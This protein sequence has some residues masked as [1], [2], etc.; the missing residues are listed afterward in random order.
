MN[1]RVA[2]VPLVLLLAVAVG[3]CEARP[4]AT[5]PATAAALTW[6]SAINLPFDAGQFEAA[7]RGGG[8][9]AGDATA[10]VELGDGWMPID[11]SDGSPHDGL[12]GARNGL[13]AWAEGGR[14][15]TSI[16]GLSWTD[17]VV[18]PGEANVAAIVPLGDNLV[19]LGEGVGRRIGAWTSSDGTAWSPLADAP[20]GMAAGTEVPGPG[21]VAVGRTGTDAAAWL[22]ADGARWRA[23]PPVR[24]ADGSAMAAVTQGAGSVVAVGTIGEIVVTWRSDDLETWSA[25]VLTAENDVSIRRIGYV[26]GMFVIAGQLNDKPTLWQS[27]DGRA[28]LA[29]QLPIPAA[30]SGTAVVIREVGDRVLVFGY[31]MEDMGNGGAWPVAH[32]VWILA[33][34]S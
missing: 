31:E 6:R 12:V 15:Q 10:W 9:V 5:P 25:S 26:R 24:D 14:V 8:V 30:T 32:L 17:A 19:M 29:S 4:E 3:G 7:A 34:S 22:T 2:R 28:W 20:L 1:P 13:V 27:T 21:L 11:A 33:P 16:A 18:G 23:I